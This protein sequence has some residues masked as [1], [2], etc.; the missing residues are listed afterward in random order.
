MGTTL[1]EPG[2][3]REAVI[4]S[5]D[6]L[7]LG[8][9]SPDE[10]LD[11]NPADTYL[12]GILWPRG[13]MIG[14][15]EDEGSAAA[16]GATDEDASPDEAVAGYRL[17]RP[18]SI[19]I[20]FTV[21]RGATITVTL[22]GTARY[23]PRT[24]ASDDEQQPA[25]AIDAAGE[26][27]DVPIE[28][29]AAQAQ[30][31]A[32][33]KPRHKV[34]WARIPI[35]YALSVPVSDT[36]SFLRESR[37]RRSDGSILE[38]STIR[39][40]VKQRPVGTDV[41]VTVTLINEEKE[42]EGGE[43]DRALLFQA[44]IS[45]T[46]IGSHGEA[47][48][49][50]RP[51]R[52]LSDDD[53]A[54]SNA[55]IHRNA[56]EFAV[57]H[58]VGTAWS[59]PDAGAVGT[60][61]T[62]WIPRQS[63]AGTT[64]EGHSLLAPLRVRSP[65][66]FA[67]AWL[68]QSANRRDACA[69]LD[70]F[71]AIYGLWI[72][73]AIREPAAALDDA[74][75]RTA[76]KHAERCESA[77][78][79]MARGVVLLRTDDRAWAAFSLANEAMNAQS[80]YSAKGSRARPLVWHPFQLA[81]LLMTL[82]SIVDPADPDRGIM[83]LLWFPTGGGKTE[84]YLGL[85]AFTIFFR[86]LSAPFR[87]QSGGVDV[88]MRYTLRL[89]TVQQFQRAAAL[90]VACDRIRRTDEDRLG[91][92]PISLG[93]YVGEE[94]TPNRRE[95]ARKSIE[96]ERAGAQVRSTPRLLLAC[97][98]CGSSLGPNQYDVPAMAARLEIRCGSPTC[99]ERG[100]VLPVTTI[101]EDIYDAPT[102]LLIGTVDK[103]AQLPRRPDLRALF[104]RDTPERP[105]LIIQDELHL[106]SGPLGSMVGL[107]ETIVDLLCTDEKGRRPKII[108][109]TATIGRA[110]KQVRA[111]FDREVFQFP[112]PGIDSADSFFSV[113]DEKG[114]DRVYI[115]VSSSGRS[116][117]FALQ[118]V[119]GAL[120][121]GIHSL[122]ELHPGADAAMDPYWTC[123]AYFNSLRELGGAYVMLQDDVP[124]TMRFLARRLGTSIRT[125]KG[126]PMELSG[127]VKSREIPQCLAALERPLAD[128]ADPFAA[129]P[130]DAVLA[131]NMISV[132]VDVPRLGL[133]V[134]NGQPKSTAEYIQAT[135]RVGRTRPGLVVTILNFGRPRDLS[136]FEHFRGYHQALYRGVEAT[137]V[138]PWAP[139]A[140]DKALHAVLLASVR[141]LVAGLRDD[142]AAV[143]F[144][145]DPEVDA[146]VSSIA[147]RA[148]EGGEGLESPGTR[149]D[150]ERIVAIWS[151]RSAAQRAAKGALVYWAP[152]FGAPA[153]P[154]LMRD[155]ERTRQS[156]TASWA[157]PNSL[158][159]IEPS[160]VFVLK[161][162]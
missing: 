110:R 40:D 92:A 55:L 81:F 138:T 75:R 14:A 103:F 21:R 20:T 104:G 127:R 28:E 48:I 3:V 43:R 66:P 5:L 83:D 39:V 146:I 117:K 1:S 111:L 101:D 52:F 23:E 132:G 25:V 69:A 19:G 153:K 109:S 139:R 60:V 86:R 121:Q 155:A 2:D 145:V 158:R 80:Q 27:P 136:H 107:Y 17:M 156:D 13:V 42:L 89:L 59:E 98:V 154:H 41:I 56:L 12:T 85:T 118:G 143:R 37:F 128:P 68:A 91:V 44:G 115:G 31:T 10:V 114:P 148:E 70:E 18:C 77:R 11:A 100:T 36:S 30:P 126:D 57:G 150:L 4:A 95:A 49:L 116:P 160:T 32:G 113:R 53:D 61:R 71:V 76:L 90:I 46:A 7:L 54:R 119:V 135:S 74:L 79:R 151:E 133:M 149:L 45:A 47:A 130:E 159:E 88:V 38:D 99:S 123:L 125:F 22:A 58:G 93:L 94:N 15:E 62:A 64:P 9:M 24:D 87:R 134:V 35:D 137:S 147:R 106:I 33:R 129:D 50:A 161:K 152:R 142:S 82:P 162:R 157:T 51:Q 73:S 65:S 67:A 16:G 105:S 144:E 97:P 120:M 78:R 102:S 72:G 84:A 141:H 34:R 124:R 26:H 122:R 8:P 108:G 140:R 131:S 112:P 96:E 6:Q 29:Q 63:V